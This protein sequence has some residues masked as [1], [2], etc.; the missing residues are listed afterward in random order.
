MERAIYACFDTLDDAQKAV[1]AIIRSG[2][3]PATVRIA[4]NH[5]GAGEGHH[6]TDFN[7]RIDSVDHNPVKDP[8]AVRGNEGPSFDDKDLSYGA[9]PGSFPDMRAQGPGNSNGD[10][11][12]FSPGTRF[13]GMAAAA[14][15]STSMGGMTDYLWSSLPADVAENLK[16]QYADGKAIVIVE[17]PSAQAEDI[18]RQQ[19]SKHVERQGY[20]A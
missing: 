19:G 17:E 5:T 6:Q 10:P 14:S 4:C 16:A 15:G 8:N 2:A 12:D 9:M 11:G 1:G 3:S 18:L 20:L 7:T 13:A